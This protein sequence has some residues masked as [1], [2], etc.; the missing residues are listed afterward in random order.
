MKLT[1]TALK[2]EKLNLSTIFYQA[3][4]KMI[5]ELDFQLEKYEVVY[6]EEPLIED[7]PWEI[8]FSHRNFEYNISTKEEFDKVRNSPYSGMVYTLVFEYD[9]PVKDGKSQGVVIY[10][11]SNMS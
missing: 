6:L 11:S 9:I 7:F 1:V 8:K 5:E 4:M 3:M 2:S 10:T